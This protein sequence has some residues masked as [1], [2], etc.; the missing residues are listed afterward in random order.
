MRICFERRVRAAV[1]RAGRAGFLL[2]LIGGAVWPWPGVV[3]ASTV[4]VDSFSVRY[5]AAAGERNLLSASP[6]DRRTFEL[7]D[8]GAVITAA[9]GCRQL[10]EHAVR[11]RS[12]SGDLFRLE[13]DLGD[14]DDTLTWSTPADADASEGEDVSVNADGGPGSDVLRVADALNNDRP[15]YARLSGGTGDDR[16]WGGAN[17]DSLDGGGGRDELYGGPGRDWLTDGDRDGATADTAP[18]PDIIDGGSPDEAAWQCCAPSGDRVIYSERTNP[19]AVDLRT[20]APNGEQGEGDRI[21]GVES[22]DGGTGND[23]L[24]GGD[25][26]GVLRGGR[27]D[28]VI[29]GGPRADEIEGDA[30]DDQLTGDAGADW[31]KGGNG[32]DRVW[33][34]GGGDEL[35]G[36]NGTD[37]LSGADGRDRMYGHGGDDRILGGPGHD[38]VS[39]GAGEDTL[40]CGAGTDDVIEPR[41][42]LIRFGCERIAF[43]KSGQDEGDANIDMAVAAHPSWQGWPWFTLRVGCPQFENVDDPSD[44]GRL[45]PQGELRITTPRSPRRPLAPTATITDAPPTCATAGGRAGV[46]VR[47]PLTALGQRLTRRKGGTLAAVALK[48]RTRIPDGGPRGAAIFRAAWTI[49][50]GAPR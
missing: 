22:V 45:S 28:D 11:C 14:M 48:V 31:I 10:S 33:G 5:V 20:E 34:E 41:R 4:A 50:L 43:R 44:T 40:K 38:R 18:G 32:D 49:R 42:E 15:T 37:R 30:G 25:T 12:T 3:V 6:V 35:W 13:A 36:E 27:G 7:V 47:A 46:D 21:T 19:V 29:T 8:P 23:M 26:A 2:A 17:D 9:T 39:G 1:R 24:H 16:L